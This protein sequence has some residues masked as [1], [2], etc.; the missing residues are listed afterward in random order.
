MYTDR[1]FERARE[2]ECISTLGAGETVPDTESQHGVPHKEMN[3]L[4]PIVREKQ[5]R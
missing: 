3:E 4:I 5:A 1:E 2:R